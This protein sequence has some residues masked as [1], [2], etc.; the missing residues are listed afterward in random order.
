MVSRKDMV[1]SPLKWEH[2]IQFYFLYKMKPSENQKLK[3]PTPSQNLM[4]AKDSV[5]NKSKN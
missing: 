5:E 3:K 1:Q 2:H 4:Y